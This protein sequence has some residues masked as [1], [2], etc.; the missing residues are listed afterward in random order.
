[1]NCELYDDVLDDYV[2]GVRASDHRSDER[3]AAFEQ[4]LAGCAR[5]QALVADLTSIRLAASTLDQHMAPPRLWARIASSIDEQQRQPWW[6][7]QLGGAF[8]AWVPAAVAASIALILV[9]G[10]W[11]VWQQRR[12]ETSQQVAAPQPETES[13]P[14]EQHYDQAIAG[15]QQLAEAQNATLDPETR[16]VLTKNL[17]VIDRAIDESRAALAQEP[18]STLA[19]ESLLEALD[20][21]VALLQETVALA[22][23]TGG[24]PEET[25]GTARELNQ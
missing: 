8:S 7:R 1:M 10:G 24:G 11:N 13:I 25:A 3:F 15:L 6:R 14:A 22:S 21:K 23:D 17:A 20:T 12:V 9:A 5:C 18:A 4:H 2:D 19:Q 16:A